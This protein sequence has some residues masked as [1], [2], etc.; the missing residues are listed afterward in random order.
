MNR[1]A[2]P[3]IF[4]SVAIVC[5]F[6]VALYPRDGEPR[7]VAQREGP[8]KSRTDAPA[9]PRLSTRSPADGDVKTP[10]IA[11][12]ASTGPVVFAAPVR[13]AG[14]RQP[15]GMLNSPDVPGEAGRIASRGRVNEAPVPAV[16]VTSARGS[17]RGTSRPSTQERAESAPNSIGRL[18]RAPFTVVGSG[19]TMADVARR[20]YGNADDVESLWR[21]NRDVVS[22]PGA[23]LSPGTVLHTPA[24]RSR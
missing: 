23:P 2:L 24:P 11:A 22:G 20:V 16:R 13:Q 12:E 19:E 15:I 7:K 17:Q 10:P 9:Q 6:A 8:A 3:S 5:F 21:A 1:Q 18:A 4:L 14:A